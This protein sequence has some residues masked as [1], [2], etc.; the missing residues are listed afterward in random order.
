MDIRNIFRKKGAKKDEKSLQATQ[1]DRATGESS[2]PYVESPSALQYPGITPQK[3]PEPQARPG[4]V[5]LPRPAEPG[6]PKCPQC[7]WSVGY[8]DMR[9]SNCGFVLRQSP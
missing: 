5:V 3:K 6:L 1:D 9:C 2:L 8:T 4:P 7:G